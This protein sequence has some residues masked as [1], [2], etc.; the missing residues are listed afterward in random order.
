MQGNAI[1]I[2]RC[3][4]QF[5]GRNM[6]VADVI[7]SSRLRSAAVLAAF[8]AAGPALA[9]QAQLFPPSQMSGAIARAKPGAS[10]RKP[11]ASVEASKRI[12]S[13]TPGAAQKQPPAATPSNA[14]PSLSPLPPL[15][16]SAPPPM[17]PRASRERMH[18]CAEEWE[19]KKRTSSAALPMWR[20]FATDCLKR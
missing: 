19:K 20:T 3:I 13:A 4:A 5:A 9:Q 7:A 1:D 17:L 2:W 10:A 6:I 12:E 15:D 11:A 8:W 18:A 14:H 16:T